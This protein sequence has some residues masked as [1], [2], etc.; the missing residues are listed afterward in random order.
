MFTLDTS[1]LLPL[2]KSSGAKHFKAH[3]A[4]QWIIPISEGGLIVSVVN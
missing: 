1:I 2:T 3:N 4:L